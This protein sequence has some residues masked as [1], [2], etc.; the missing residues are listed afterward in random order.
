MSGASEQQHASNDGGTPALQQQAPSA[1]SLA[2][3]LNA[4]R[5]AAFDANRPFCAPWTVLQ[6][7]IPIQDAT[8]AQQVPNRSHP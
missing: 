1:E 5:W 8:A 7:Y 3:G 6:P 4:W 2:Y